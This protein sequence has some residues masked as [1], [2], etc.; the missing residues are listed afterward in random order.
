MRLI[1]LGAPGSG[2]GTI[3][4]ELTKYYGVLHIST[5]DIFRANMKEQTPLG[6][7]AKKV[8]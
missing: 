3:A 7:E 6:Q 1:L 5:G 4:A 8:Y 2:K